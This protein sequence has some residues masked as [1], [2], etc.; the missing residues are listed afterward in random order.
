MSSYIQKII[1]YIL[2]YLHLSGLKEGRGSKNIQ[3]QDNMK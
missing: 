3:K 1:S 2:Q